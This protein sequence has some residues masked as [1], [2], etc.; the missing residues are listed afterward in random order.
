MQ[1]FVPIEGVLKG[2]R[3][4]V[5]GSGATLGPFVDG[6][7]TGTPMVRFLSQPEPGRE[8]RQIVSAQRNEEHSGLAHLSVDLSL[9]QSQT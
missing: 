1:R 4:W 9:H 8:R 3:S 5:G 7:D 2:R 6:A